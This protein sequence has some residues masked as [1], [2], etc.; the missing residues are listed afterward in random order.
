VKILM[1]CYEFP[2]IGGGG[3]QVVRGLAGELVAAGHDVDL[4]T[5][6]FRGL[7]REEEIEG[8]RVHRV[9]C[10]RRKEFVCTAPEAATYAASAFPAVLRLAAEARPDI[11]HAHFIFPDGFLAWS[12]RRRTGLPY[13]I[14]AHGSDVP[15]YNPH[16]LKAAHRLLAPLWSSVTGGARRIVCPSESL[17][18]LVSAACPE[19]RTTVI[20]NGIDP[21]A[22]RPD[23]RKRRRI[24]V[25]TRM[26]ERKGA[27]HVMTALGGAS[28]GYELHLVGD[29][30]YLP[31]LRELARDLGVNA[32]F[33]GWL[34]NRSPE[35]R[36]LFET[37][38]IFALPSEAESFGVVLLEAMAAGMAIVTSAGTGCA[39]VVGDAGLLVPPRDPAAVRDALSVLAADPARCDTLGRAA[40]RRLEERFGWP[41]VGRRYVALY[42]ETVAGGG[43]GEEGV[44]RRPAPDGKGK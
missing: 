27:Q 6:G 8:I 9:P 13:V 34:S 43:R 35:Y 28:L 5:M 40:R 26:L 4:V 20:P 17:R 30:P 25:A 42:E 22:F 36:D 32:V 19:A 44:R 38:A 24:L 41:A 18:R 1:L 31:V 14:T 12:T 15:G 21:A 11:V 7:P 29:G 3:A 23:R 10:L 37:S 2:P 16:R 39:E 33:H